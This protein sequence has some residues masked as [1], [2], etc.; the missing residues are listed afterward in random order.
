MH[1]GIVDGSGIVLPPVP[2][3]APPVP[4]SSGAVRTQDPATM[5]ALGG[6]HSL[7]MTSSGKV[8]GFG[9]QENGRLGVDVESVRAVGLVVT[10]AS[11]T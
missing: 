5:V 10:C 7:V 3:P 2:S 4:V 6:S 9:R 1:T 11:T 8:F